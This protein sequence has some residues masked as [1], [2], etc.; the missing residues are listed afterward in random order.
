MTP[1]IKREMVSRSRPAGGLGSRIN[2]RGLRSSN[3]RYFR[4][5]VKGIKVIGKKRIAFESQEL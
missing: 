4:E 3:N 5:S 2:R 1:G